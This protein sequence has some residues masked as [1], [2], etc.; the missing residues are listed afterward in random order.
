MNYKQAVKKA[1]LVHEAA[2]KVARETR[3]EAIKA[4]WKAYDEK[5]AAATKAFQ[6]V[7]SS[8]NENQA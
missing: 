4:A 2:F 3:L 7:L 8:D 6:E 1:W 5:A